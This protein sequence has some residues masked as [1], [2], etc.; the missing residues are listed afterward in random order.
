[1]DALIGHTGFVGSTLIRARAFDACYN[2]TSIDQIDGRSFDLL[3]CAGASAAK[4]QANQNPDIDR[5]SLERLKAHLKTVRAQRLVLIST[6]DVF[7]SPIDVSELDEPTSVGLLPYGRH[8][9]ELEHFIRERFDQSIIIRLPGLFGEGLKK[10]LI[11]DLVHNHLTHQINPLGLLQ[12]YPMR[13]FA[14]DLSAII[15]AKPPLIHVAAEPIATLDIQ[16]RFFPEAIIGEPQLPAPT[17]DMRTVL[18]QILGGSGQYH[19]SAIDVMRELG[20]YVHE[21]R[22]SNP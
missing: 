12:W 20:R 13:R 8:R 5:R 7:S 17:Y 10:N 11:H 1:M 18:P 14:D 9:L 4:W 16:N 21:T 15:D 19:L 2:S 22:G 3:V 6:V